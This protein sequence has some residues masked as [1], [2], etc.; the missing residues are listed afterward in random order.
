MDWLT[1]Q[2]NAKTLRVATAYA[3]CFLSCAAHPGAPSRTRL[4]S[5]ALAGL[6]AWLFIRACRERAR[7]RSETG[8][9]RRATLRESVADLRRGGSRVWRTALAIAAGV[10]AGYATL[11]GKGAAAAFGLG[12]LYGVVV[13]CVA[14][15]PVDVQSGL[16]ASFPPPAA[17][18]GFRRRLGADALYVI[19]PRWLGRDRCYKLIIA[20]AALCLAYLGSR[21]KPETLEFG[22]FYERIN[23]LGEEFLAADARNF[24][25]PREDIQTVR[26]DPQRKL[27]LAGVPH[28]GALT[29]LLKSGRRYEF[30][31]LGDERDESP[32]SVAR[33][34]D[35]CGVTSFSVMR[36]TAHKEFHG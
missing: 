28:W 24:R 21:P 16:T 18:N 6:A 32:V 34:L 20:E 11:G 15:Y 4:F 7:L 12:A 26:F 13:L 2:K 8:T 1:A 17:A 33:L 10:A 19:Q 31:V 27:W 14:R 35:G 9:T 3:L 5:A 30:I 25:I 36:R 29:V 23:P 22:R